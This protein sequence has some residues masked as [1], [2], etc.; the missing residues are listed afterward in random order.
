MLGTWSPAPTHTEPRS[1]AGE[2]VQGGASLQVH[3]AQ[4]RVLAA[5]QHLETHLS[6]RPRPHT[7]ALLLSRTQRTAEFSDGV[8]AARFSSRS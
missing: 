3:L 7:H 1:L 8:D 6:V 4:L 2:T 5:P